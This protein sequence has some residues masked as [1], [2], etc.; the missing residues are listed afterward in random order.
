MKK[1]FAFMLLMIFNTHLHAK[2]NNFRLR[3]LNPF[4]WEYHAAMPKA[5]HYKPEDYSKKDKVQPNNKD[6]YEKA[7]K[8]LNVN[9]CDVNIC[10]PVNTSK[11][12]FGW[13]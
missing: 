8:S 5:Y 9:P 10:E 13:F 1:V 11:S 12:G 7:K 4:K 2:H 6:D 3:T